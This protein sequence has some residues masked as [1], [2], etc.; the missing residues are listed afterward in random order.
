MNN[1]FDQFAENYRAIHTENVKGL[2]GVDSDYFSKYK[3]EEIQELIN[4]KRILD[5]GC[6]DGI[7]AKYIDELCDAKSYIGI[8]VSQKSI[9][10]ATARNLDEKYSFVIYDGK[11]IPCDDNSLDVVFIA[12]VIHHINVGQRV[13]ILK[14]CMRVLVPGGHIIIFEHNPR[15][16]LTLKTVETCPFDEG[17][18]LIKERELR[19]TLIKANFR[20]IKVFYTIF[21]PRKGVFEKLLPLEKYLKWCCM[22]GQYYLIAT[23]PR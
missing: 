9:Q 15:N 16:L 17:A 22:G 7:S 10:E 12:C 19:Q 4:G 21:M 14:E 2:S 5:L 13:D 8:D 18:I 1:E 20:M 11:H 3:I 23:K 6:G